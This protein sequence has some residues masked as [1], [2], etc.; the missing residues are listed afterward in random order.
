MQV[1]IGIRE[2]SW[3][4]SPASTVLSPGIGWPIRLGESAVGDRGAVFTLS[5][6]LTKEA[7]QKI[8][9]NSHCCFPFELGKAYLGCVCTSSPLDMW[10]LPIEGT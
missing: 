5:H 4:I 1:L 3:V 6:D 2:A 9:L 8:S 10:A 7:M